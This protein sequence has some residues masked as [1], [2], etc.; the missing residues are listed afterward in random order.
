MWQWVAVAAIAVVA[1]VLVFGRRSR[2]GDCCGCALADECG[3][4]RRKEKCGKGKD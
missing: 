3:K 1:A 4:K 2:K